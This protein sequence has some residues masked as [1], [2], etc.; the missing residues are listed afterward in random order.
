MDEKSDYKLEKLTLYLRTL[1]EL[2][3]AIKTKV[4]EVTEIDRK[5][6]F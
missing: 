2:R 3:D 5:K 6:I 1:N 4:D